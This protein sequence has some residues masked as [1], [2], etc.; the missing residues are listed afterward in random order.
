M[1]FRNSREAGDIKDHTHMVSGHQ[2]GVLS[3]QVGDWTK[4]QDF[5]IWR[6]NTGQM[7]L[8]KGH[9]SGKKKR[10][11]K[12]KVRKVITRWQLF[13]VFAAVMQM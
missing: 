6:R 1:N 4:L 10:V 9:Y 7:C 2:R 5:N 12:E 3:I 13:R 8:Q 11:S